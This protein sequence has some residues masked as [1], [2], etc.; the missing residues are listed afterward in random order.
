M[1]VHLPGTPMPTDESPLLDQGVPDA[2]PAVALAKR[3]VDH[4]DGRGH[5]VCARQLLA[6]RPRMIDILIRTRHSRCT[7][8]PDGRATIELLNRVVS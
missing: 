8:R 1:P 4:L 2:W 6:L 7:A 5:G 3:S